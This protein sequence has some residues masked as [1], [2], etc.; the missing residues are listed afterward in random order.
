MHNLCDLIHFT[1]S[2]EIQFNR[3][4]SVMQHYVGL[5]PMF[6]LEVMNADASVVLG[7]PDSQP[8]PSSVGEGLSSLYYEITSMNNSSSS[9]RTL[10]LKCSL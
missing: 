4:T 2:F 6:D 8:D 10:A 9:C 1:I 3:G 7:D 5:R